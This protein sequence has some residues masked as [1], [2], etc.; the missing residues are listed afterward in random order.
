PPISAAFPR[1]GGKRREPRGTK[2]GIALNRAVVAEEA[3]AAARELLH[4]AIRGLD[5]LPPIDLTF[6]DYL[7]AMITADLQLYPNDSKYEYRKT[8]REAFASFGISPS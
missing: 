3:A 8:L 5:Y 6:G 4:I 2:R 1:V 7:S